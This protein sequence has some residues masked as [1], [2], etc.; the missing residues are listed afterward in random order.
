MDTK[1]FNGFPIKFDGDKM[2]SLTDL[3]KASGKT[4]DYKPIQWTRKEGSDFIE[5]VAQKLMVPVGHLFQ[6]TK[7]RNG[8]TYAHKQIAL[9]YAKYLSPELHMFVNEVFFERLEEMANPDL[10]LT[11]GHD[12]AVEGYRRKGMDEQWIT[13][14]VRAIDTTLYSNRVIAAHG[15]DRWAFPM[16]HDEVNKEILGMTS[17]EFKETH[18]LAKTSPIRDHLDSIELTEIA[19]AH[20]LATRDIVKDDVHGNAACADIY[21]QRASKVSKAAQ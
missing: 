1:E 5:A 8:G 9:A 13:E 15:D 16:C 4:L 6:I 11:R 12:R 3:W 17:K 7:G 18:E 2:V 19:L 20:Q 21:R 14:R 10:A